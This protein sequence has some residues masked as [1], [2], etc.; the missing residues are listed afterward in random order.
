MNDPDET[1]MLEFQ[2]GSAAAFNELFARY[3]NPLH[4]FFQSRLAAW[5]RASIRPES[6]LGEVGAKLES[7][8]VR[9]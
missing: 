2:S 8:G 7:C 3:P 6:P 9:Q 4:G 1:L 5:V